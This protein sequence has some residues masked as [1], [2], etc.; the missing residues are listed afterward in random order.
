MSTKKYFYAKKAFSVFVVFATILWTL[1]PFSLLLNKAG[2]TSATVSFYGSGGDDSGQ[3][4][5]F[6]EPM[7]EVL[8][9]SS[10][11]AGLFSFHIK[12][13]SGSPTLT[14]VKVTLT[15]G[16]SGTLL[17][18]DIAGLAVFKR[19]HSGDDYG[20]GWYTFPDA[21]KVG[22][23]DNSADGSGGL[24]TI[25]TNTIT[26]TTTAIPTEFWGE[27]G[28]EY[29][30]A[31]KTS[32]N[33]A[34]T[35]QLTYTLPADW[36]TVS[37]GTLGSVCP[38]SGDTCQSASDILYAT[39][40]D[41][42]VGEQFAVHMVNYMGTDSSN[43]HE[44]E[45]MFSDDVDQ[46]S[47]ELVTNYNIGG[48]DPDSATRITPMTI[49]LIFDSG[50]TVNPNQTSLT[51]EGGGVQDL[52]G[53]TLTADAV[54]MIM[55]GGDG[56]GGDSPLMI[57]EVMVGTGTGTSA[58]EEFIELFNPS[59]AGVDLSTT[60]IKVW[61]VV[62]ISGTVTHTKFASL[63]SGTV[64]ANGY[65]LV[66]SSQ[67][68][69]IDPA[70]D[71]SYDATIGTCDD[72]TGCLRPNAGVYLSTSDAQNIAVFERLGWGTAPGELTSGP[73]ATALTNNGQSLE[74]KANY[75]STALTMVSSGAD[76]TNGN[77][78]DTHDNQYDFV[79]IPAV[80]VVPQSS[81][82]TAE[83]PGGAGYDE[84][85]NNYPYINHDPL[86]S[87]I[88]S[89]DLIAIAEVT[90][91]SGF[92]SA[93]NI[94]LY[95]RTNTP[96]GTWTSASATESGTNSYRFNIPAS[97]LDATADLDYYIRAYDGTNYTCLP[98]G[99]DGTSS[100]CDAGTDLIA[101]TSTAYYIDVAAT[102][103]SGVISGRV[104]DT[105]STPNGIP[106]VL[107]FTE[108]MPFTATTNSS[109][110]F[111]IS[112]LSDGVYDLRAQGGSYTVSGT[113]ANYLEG[114]LSGIYLNSSVGQSS[115]G[116]TMVLSQGTVTNRGGTSADN[117]APWVM[118][119]AP[120]D[121]MQGYPK[122]DSLIV[123]F[124]KAMQS[125]VMTGGTA[126]TDNIY[127]ID[128][129]GT[130][131]TAESV[132][133]CDDSSGSDSCTSGTRD[134]SW[135][136]AS[137]DPN[138]LIY[139]PTTDLS[140]GAGYTLVLSDRLVGQNGERLMGN[141]PNGGHS[142]GFS[143][144]MDYGQDGI[145]GDDAGDYSF[146]SGA[147]FPPYIVATTP[148]GGGYD[149]A[150]NIKINITFN[151]AMSSTSI[152]TTNIRLYSVSNPY[153]SGET[154]TAVSGYTVTQNNAGDIAT[155]TPGSNL[156]ESTHYRVK[157]LSNCTS[158][159]GTP[160]S[161][162]DN[163]EQ[164]RLDFDVGTSLDA[165][166]PTVAGTYPDADATSI[167][168]N[169]S[170][171]NI[172]FSEPMDPS[173]I[174]ARTVQL[175]R[176][177]SAVSGTVEYNVGEW[178]AYFMPSQ[179]LRPS[180]T[181]TI[182][183]LSGASGVTDV[184]GNQLVDD[185]ETDFTTDSTID[186]TAPFI[187]FARCDD[188]SCSITFS[189]PMKSVRADDSAANYAASVLKP[190]NYA[191]A[192]ASCSETPSTSGAR[193][194][195]DQMNNTARLEGVSG[196]QYG[197]GSNSFTITVSNV[198][199]K[200]GN[201]IGNPSTFTANVENSM[202]TGGMMGP[203][204]Y[205]PM[206]GPPTMM[207]SG[208]NEYGDGGFSGPGGGGGPTGSDMSAG[209]GGGMGFDFGGHWEEPV[210]C[211]P[212]NQM[213][214][215]TTQYM[216]E[217]KADTAIESGGTIKITF[218]MGTDVSSAEEVPTTQ[219][220]SNKDINGQMDSTTVTISA[221]A[222][223]PVARTVT[224]TTSGAISANDFV[225]F[226]IKGIANPTVPKSHETNGYTA[227]IKTF[228]TS[229]TLLQSE[230]TMNYFIN[231]SGDYTLSGT[232][233]TTG[234]NTVSNG[235]TVSVYM[236][237]WVTGP[238]EATA[239]FASGSADYSFTGLPE[240]DYHIHTEPNF[241]LTTNGGSKSYIGYMKPES[242]WV[243]SSN[244]TAGEC[245]STTT[246]DK[247]FSITQESTDNAHELTVRIFV[248]F[249]GSDF[250]ESGDREIDIWAGGPGSHAM[251]TVTLAQQDYTTTPYSANLYVTS[252]GEYWV[253]M[254]PA[255]PKGMMMM[256][257][258]P[259]PSWMPPQ[260]VRVQ[261]SGNLGASTYVETSNTAN[262]GIL[263]FTVGLAENQIIGYVVDSSGTAI[264]NV[265]ID[266][267]R[268]QGGMGMPSH[269][270]TD[271][272][273][274]FVLKVSTGVYEV[275]A[276]MP[277][278][279]WSPGKTVIVEADSS[280]VATDNN[281]TADV[282]KNGVVQAGNLVLDVNDSTGLQIKL[283]KSST[284]ISGTLLDNNDSPV[285]YA[286]V[287]A[288]NQTTGE[289]MPS[290]TDS[291]GAYT[292]YV[293]DG[294]W[295]VEAYL[296][297]LGDV[298]YANN[299]VAVSGSSVSGI[300]I[301]PSSDVSFATIT[302][303]IS[304]VTYGNI[305]VE[306]SN[307]A[308]G[309]YHNGTNVNSS[310]EYRL[311]VP[312]PASGSVTYQLHAWLPDYGDLAPISVAVSGTTTYTGGTDY[313]DF[314]V[315]G[316]KTLTLNFTGY[317]NVESGT[318]AFVDVFKPG[319][320]MGMGKGNHTRIDDLYTTSS[321]TLNLPADSGYEIN[322]YIPGIGGLSP[323]C[324]DDGT[325][326]LCT[327]SDPDTWQIVDSGAVTFDLTALGDLYTV[328][329]TVNT[330]NASSTTIGDT[331]VWIGGTTSTGS[332][333]HSGEPANSDTG[334]ATIKVP[335][336]DANGY[337][338]GADKPGYTSPAPTSLVVSAPASTTISLATNPYTLSGTIY[339]PDGTTPV[340]RAWIWADKVTSATDFG[341][342]GG[343]TGT[344]TNPDGTYELSISNGYWMV[345]AVSDAYNEATYQVSG[346]DTAIQINDASVISADI[347]MTARSGYTATEPKSAPVTPASGGTVDDLDGT[348]VKLTIPASALGSGTSAGTVNITETN[349]LP[350]TQ[351][352]IP[353]EGT[354]T[355]INVTNSAGQAITSLSGS[356]TMDMAYTEADLPTG[357]AEGDLI[358]AYYDDSSNQ[359]I[360]L[361][362]SQDTTNDTISGPTTHFSD[363][364]LV[365]ARGDAPSTP[366]GLAA[367]AASS[368]Q[369]NLSWTATD[370][371]SGYY[372]YSSET[373]GGTF[374]LLTTITS[375]S[376]VT[377]SDTS[378]SASTPYYYKIASYYLSDINES[379]A[380][381]EVTATTSAA[382]TSGGGGW[383][384]PADPVC[385]NGTRE[386]SEGCD[387]G[388]LIDGDGCSKIC[389]LEEDEIEDEVVEEKPVSK[390]SIS[391][392]KAKIL[393]LT[394]LVANLQA[395]LINT[396]S[397]LFDTSN[398][399]DSFSFTKTLKQGAR[400]DEVK[401]M[402][403]LIGT[404]ADG[405][406][407]PQTKQKVIE[408]QEQYKA[409]ILDPWNLEKGTG[410]VGKT[411]RAKL[412]ELLDK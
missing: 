100:S 244:A 264:S 3:P 84:G 293:G 290:G 184:V 190:G 258:P 347:T 266:A 8:P 305:W 272:D 401:Y 180:A 311:S 313:T 255:M 14:N 346:A 98:P 274:R 19:V 294:N 24:I 154:E 240:A 38:S 397:G 91:D 391:E 251:K 354:G 278:M 398:I 64:P 411:T 340:S 32:S 63:N 147:S 66:A 299:P 370:N 201:A 222:N 225:M 96:A 361:P 186:T 242:I 357:I 232:I 323:T 207:D 117:E 174:N 282:Y 59:S 320:G 39:A 97:A 37:D 18:N 128:A 20:G 176:G 175:K 152:N 197:A 246:C 135:P 13:D 106:D 408:F 211:M 237:S 203:G 79:Q 343:W 257:P 399:P 168:T 123:V 178:A 303:S 105:E 4:F 173:T 170:A 378:L 187:E 371:T 355:T 386:P 50:V 265:D 73:A 17:A 241:A 353:L 373:S 29:Y 380:S 356:V 199:D 377:Y 410:L 275:N 285:S 271:D 148:G 72:A 109:G 366:S 1:G 312:T 112:G 166:A 324:A 213:A 130:I 143:A 48:T 273:G 71:T 182:D 89:Q 65:Y 151:E 364:A 389:V 228:D 249:S 141:R 169:I 99:T 333:F 116:H 102:G 406:F 407:G 309:Y 269:A 101:S 304:G 95:Y 217:F 163:G 298:S 245:N 302:G 239:T 259:M 369:I 292:I 58:L 394:A 297:G 26:A 62:N 118:W 162:A 131:V 362:A 234:A 54:M 220:M 335:A 348:G 81:A 270:Q 375:S 248:D 363:F 349:T 342:A 276:W 158:A 88:A 153:A 2:A 383:I 280:N 35:D 358:L 5:Y 7:G 30:V 236:D 288:Y 160:M 192:C 345:R 159:D 6:I 392:I 155:I 409:D 49:R 341:F 360:E 27:N 161:N 189:E 300:D 146:G 350:I 351:E 381:S 193:A 284:T 267:H 11:Y 74:R 44:I 191:I 243:S 16:G 133:Y 396:V 307:P 253:G 388:N 315:S 42:W 92:I 404:D 336:S 31:V 227:D 277:G 115:T 76:E 9:A 254:G 287:W 126:T 230:T 137:D 46:T 125:S 339:Q 400:G 149:T 107:V 295:Y 316:M 301:R 212:M 179:A 291:S 328:T 108:G 47:A 67:Y 376:T 252:T 85:S 368:S 70:A 279:P 164:F 177:T 384:P 77:M 263:D 82:S 238:L 121:M 402:Q 390:M 229:N 150:R 110:Y 78:Y 156:T 395:S 321:T 93:S 196:L 204:G 138:L 209:M 200:T 188:Y 94:K 157:V 235:Q 43:N 379:A 15:N 103:G 87:A 119:S 181:Y 387:D 69:S 129:D 352:F 310:G 120:H 224:V 205:G 268:T 231:E 104:E 262:D 45:V 113:T 322:V 247:D 385:G 338:I 185:S 367:T 329:V 52:S 124:D 214:G 308:G 219:S 57:S 23:I 183:I 314:S 36:I 198:T 206:M 53:T 226:D 80:S 326:V 283:D 215:A 21:D 210:H 382:T 306:G 412:N 60:N 34:G 250:S 90:D 142:I 25:G 51:I 327:D 403:I 194:E 331:F 122:G 374:A 281:S 134:S 332:S 359:Y 75:D 318:E 372:I 325:N 111:T 334:I 33:W 56:P 296:P 172:G 83:T 136:S 145:G 256:G 317:A 218:P 202:A 61:A 260:D 140:P 114:W 330:V 393:E 12:K 40:P 216:C 132:I 167:S 208:G 195:Y 261:I 405:I 68:S 221:V 365:Y 344:E 165:T 171:I 127:L 144:A 22:E 55:G 41:G 223:N 233:S 286:P 28:A 10:G 86:Y 319:S 289:H 337:E 139:N